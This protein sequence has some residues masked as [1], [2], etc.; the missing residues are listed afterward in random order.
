MVPLLMHP[1]P[2]SPPPPALQGIGFG[3]WVGKGKVQRQAQLKLRMWWEQAGGFSHQSL[4]IPSLP[5]PC[6]ST[7]R[8]PVCQPWPSQPQ[9]MPCS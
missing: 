7:P 6:F 3:G 5:H 4:N 9:C 2:P 1:T 8:S